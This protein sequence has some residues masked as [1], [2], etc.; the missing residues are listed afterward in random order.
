VISLV[1]VGGDARS[2]FLL[3][4]VVDGL[5]QSFDALH[6]RVVHGSSLAVGLTEAVHPFVFAQLL[7]Q[8][9][10]VGFKLSLFLF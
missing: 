7:P 4:A 1:F 10:C 9:I 6:A 5:L 8:R 2:Q 3:V